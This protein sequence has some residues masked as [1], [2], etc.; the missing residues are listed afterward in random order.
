MDPPWY[1]FDPGFLNNLTQTRDG[2]QADFGTPQGHFIYTLPL[3]PAQYAPNA[4]SG[5]GD[6]TMLNMLALDNPPVSALNP[7]TESSTQ[8]SYALATW[9]RSPCPTS[10]LPVSHSMCTLPGAPAYDL[11][12]GPTFDLACDVSAT[13]NHMLPRESAWYTPPNQQVG[14]WLRSLV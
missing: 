11:I 1:P 5:I 6:H 10:H 4:S 8:G 3:R 9:G 13:M 12:Q 14:V 7:A 2:E